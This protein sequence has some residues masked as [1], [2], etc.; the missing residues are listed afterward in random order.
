[1]EISAVTVTNDPS[2]T[3][4]AVPVN[5]HEC[6][7]CRRRF[8]SSRG[9]N[10][11]LRTCSKYVKE[12]PDKPP[13]PVSVPV[14]SAILYRWGDFDNTEF[15][16]NLDTVYE[17]I[18]FWRRNL[19]LLPTGKAGKRYIDEVSR[20]MNAWVEDS[21]LKNI[22][23]K[24]IMVMP[25]I[26]LQK[27]S[28][29]SKS[30]DHVKALERRLCLW[31]SGNILEL[32]KESKAIQNNLQSINKPETI[33]EISKRFVNMMQKGN[34]NGA[35]K[36]LSNNMQNGV[37]PLTDD[38]LKLLKIKHPEPA[39]TSADVLLT[40]IP[41]KIH[42]IKFEDINA[43]TI[44]RAAIN[45][46]GGSGPSGMDAD[47]WRTLFVSNSFGDSSSDL[48][49]AFACAVRKLCTVDHLQDSLE[50]FLACRLIPLDKNPGLR[51]IGVGEILR[52]IAGK[53]LLPVL[54]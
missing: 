7:S 29:N 28:K 22:A 20:L 11:H 52:R 12:P 40:D 42:P 21:P 44:R 43:D 38:T 49:K 50:A 37:L 39:E 41:E 4:E 2:K 32:L 16:V 35:I 3:A 24:A 36:L 5:E 54:T 31:N 23:F 9:L 45:T 34:V 19:F 14:S 25:S 30:K 6:S 46:K 8:K 47:G 15:E 51:P 1:M 27:P 10:I 48:C 13:D 53:A 17:E 18:V 26:L 33:G